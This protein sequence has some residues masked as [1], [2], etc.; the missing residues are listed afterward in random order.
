TIIVQAVAIVG[1]WPV[2]HVVL[3]VFVFSRTSRLEE[4][5]G[6]LALWRVPPQ[7]PL[8]H[9]DAEIVPGKLSCC[10][11]SAKACA[12]DDY[13][14]AEVGHQVPPARRCDK[15][16]GTGATRVP[17]AASLEP[18]RRGPK[19]VQFRVQRFRL[20]CHPGSRTGS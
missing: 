9:H 3:P 8:Q 18:T 2:L 14:A 10:H 17:L 7:S 12:D 4:V 15:R 6:K 19:L 11:G 20:M 1:P 16:A 5:G 13:V